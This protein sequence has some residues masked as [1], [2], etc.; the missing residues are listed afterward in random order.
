MR[1]TNKI[2]WKWN[3]KILFSYV[4]FIWKYLLIY[5]AGKI[6]MAF[7]ASN[8]ILLHAK[9]VKYTEKYEKFCRQHLPFFFSSIKYML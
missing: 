5:V 9:N 4:N 6:R 7:I 2:K 3:I 8:L 1:Q